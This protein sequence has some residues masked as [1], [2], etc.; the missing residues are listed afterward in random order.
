MP[1]SADRPPA[2]SRCQPAYSDRPSGGSA[3][4]HPDQVVSPLEGLRAAL[5][6]DV[7]LVHAEGAR[8]RSINM[9]K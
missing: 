2:F 7:E 6:P 8:I 4:V 9:P 3:T 1:S 5:G